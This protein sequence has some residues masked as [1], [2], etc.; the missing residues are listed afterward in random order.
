MPAVQKY[1]PGDWVTLRV[2]RN[3]VVLKRNKYF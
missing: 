3:D 2:R 1:D